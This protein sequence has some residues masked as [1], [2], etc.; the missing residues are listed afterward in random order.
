MRQ[1]VRKE[2]QSNVAAEFQVF[3]F[4]D[5]AHS[6]AADPAEDAVVGHGL[7]HGLGGRGHWI[8]MLGVGDG[9]VNAQFARTSFLYLLLISIQYSPRSFVYRGRWLRR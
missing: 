7:S 4:I 5:H 6:P 8:D 9:K 3:R 1:F 2:L